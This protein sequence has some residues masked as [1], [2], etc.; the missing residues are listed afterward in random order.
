MQ[1]LTPIAE[2]LPQL[3]TFQKVESLESGR[4][5]KH[6]DSNKAVRSQYIVVFENGQLF[7]SYD[8][9]IG[10]KFKG[11]KLYLSE[12]HD[13]SNTTNKYCTTW[14]GLDAKERREGL[15]N[16]SIYPIENAD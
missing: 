16:G 12:K 4:S 13:F 9:I 5:Y 8:S 15:K 11:G 7:Q 1:E 14:C 10:L 6:P 3:G 2:L